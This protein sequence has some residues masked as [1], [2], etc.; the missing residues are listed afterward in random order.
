MMFYRL[1]LSQPK[2]A[3]EFDAAKKEYEELKKSIQFDDSELYHA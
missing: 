2:A 1:Y 3:A